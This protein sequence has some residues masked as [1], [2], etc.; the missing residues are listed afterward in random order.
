MAIWKNS[1]GE[2][3]NMIYLRMFPDWFFFYTMPEGMFHLFH[4]FLTLET[5]K[6]DQT[7]YAAVL[8]CNQCRTAV[9]RAEQRNH[10][11][12]IPYRYSWFMC[13]I[14]NITIYIYYHISYTY[15]YIY[16]YIGHPSTKSYE[17]MTQG[18]CPRFASIRFF[19]G[20][21]EPV[22]GPCAIAMKVIPLVN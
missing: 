5:S 17:Q 19:F 15:I 6:D 9:R 3:R 18:W 11:G 4:V 16:I 13:A 8:T 20:A 10:L 1:H 14:L 12:C 22:S 21:V 2:G 7:N